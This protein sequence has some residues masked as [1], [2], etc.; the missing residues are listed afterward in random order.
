MPWS[1]HG[2]TGFITKRVPCGGFI[3]RDLS[4]LLKRSGRQGASNH[5]IFRFISVSRPNG[6]WFPVLPLARQTGTTNPDDIVSSRP[7]N[8]SGLCSFPGHAMAR[9]WHPFRG[10]SHCTAF[11]RRNETAW[12]AGSSPA[13]TAEGL[14]QFSQPLSA[15]RHPGQA[16][17]EP[18]SGSSYVPSRANAVALRSWICALLRPGRRRRGGFGW[19]EQ[20]RFRSCHPCEGREPVIFSPRDVCRRQVQRILGPGLATDASNRDDKSG[21]SF[22][23]QI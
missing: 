16:K 7:E 15:K 4:S 9:P 10:V 18:G 14:L 8:S 13:M 11:G 23:I 2:M 5:R 3:Y 1:S 6:Y 20:T 21:G 19:L 12:I 17:R 22:R